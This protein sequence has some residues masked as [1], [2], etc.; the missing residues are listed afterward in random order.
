M[1][2]V[3]CLQIEEDAQAMIGE[4]ESRVLNIMWQ[5]HRATVREVCRRLRT[6]TRAYT[7]VMTTMDRLYQKG[8]LT[9]ELEGKAYRYT[10]RVSREEFARSRLSELWEA[11]F[12][13][14]GDPAVSCLVDVIRSD[15]REQFEKLAR[16]V[17]EARKLL[18]QRDRAER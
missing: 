16:A 17:D 11:L 8:Y 15:D 13:T 7:T 6:R 4:L 12:H 1:H 18:D 3:T 9:R 2:P 10:I 14:L 5:M